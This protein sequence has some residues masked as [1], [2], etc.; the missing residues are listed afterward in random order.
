MVANMK[1]DRI[2]YS[3]CSHAAPSSIPYCRWYVTENAWPRFI[4][5]GHNCA[6]PH[7]SSTELAHGRTQPK[8]LP[9]CRKPVIWFPF[10]GKCVISG[11]HGGPASIARI[12]GDGGL[13]E[14]G[15]HW[16]SQ[17]FTPQQCICVRM[18]ASHRTGS[19]DALWSGVFASDYG[20]RRVI[21]LA[22]GRW[23]QCSLSTIILRST[24]FA[25]PIIT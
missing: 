20:S 22:I 14:V 21:Y 23:G 24:P 9:S 8:A 19:M 25:R 2:W 3:P 13:G 11:G 7:N 4:D 18:H 6:G 12:D 17:L 10:I 5:P 15:H 1:I 16:C